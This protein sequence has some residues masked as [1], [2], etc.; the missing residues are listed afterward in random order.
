[1]RAEW[2]R[3][4]APGALPPRT[5]AVLGVIAA[6]L[7]V[8]NL[9][10]ASICAPALGCV[11]DYWART[12][13]M[14]Y[15]DGFLRRA[16]LG[17]LWDLLRSDPVPFSW[18]NLYGG[19]VVALICALGVLTLARI[20]QGQPGFVPALALV[21]GPGAM[22]LVETLGDNLQTALVL[23]L[24]AAFLPGVAGRIALIVFLPVAAMLHEVALFLLWPAALVLL[25]GQ[26]RWRLAKVVAMLGLGLALYAAL[27]RFPTPS[28]LV[29]T[30]LGGEV[31]EVRAR[32]ALTL[33]RA[34]ELEYQ[35]HF[36]SP[37]SVAK[38]LYQIVS[39]SFWPLL[40]LGVMAR[41]TGAMRPVLTY[42]GL[43][44]LSLPLY[45]IAHDWS[46]FAIFTLY[47][48]LV[49]EM[50]RVDLFG[51]RLSGLRDRIEVWV[52]RMPVGF[53]ALF[54]V[55]FVAHDN[56][57]TWGIHPANMAVIL[58]LLAAFVWL[59]RR[60]RQTA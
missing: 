6:F 3:S 35:Y 16:L 44:A 49:L 8:H 23:F 48:T 40:F 50:H 36:G 2:I 5:R 59:G 13:E 52:R 30:G 38:L 45:V 15:Q 60:D 29:F 11:T 4:D 19:V 43:L 14:S 41:I 57:R 20:L 17:S 54:P 46:R 55:L 7:V 24:L 12:W 27:P 9:H 34:L 31:V 32:A 53:V 51:A 37:A 10:A 28:T 47:A 56:Y 21:V 33:A 26:G 1:M 18:L 25:V 39:F 42:L 22:V 58:G